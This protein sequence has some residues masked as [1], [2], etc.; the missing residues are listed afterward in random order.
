M[1]G[2]FS[3]EALEHRRML[4]ASLKRGTLTVNG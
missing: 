3:C 2:G 4:S 1:S